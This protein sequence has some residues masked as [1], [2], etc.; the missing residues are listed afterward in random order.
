MS[1]MNFLETLLDFLEWIL[2]YNFSW[3]SRI[4]YDLHAIRYCVLYSA[5]NAWK[6]IIATWFTFSDADLK[7]FLFFLGYF[8]GFLW[9]CPEILY[10]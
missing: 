1:K 10:F 9:G 3:I 2:F 7:N 6:K 4:I 8:A 5:T